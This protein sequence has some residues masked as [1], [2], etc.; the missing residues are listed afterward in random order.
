MSLRVPA[1]L[2]RVLLRVAL[3][4]FI[5]PPFGFGFQRF[6]VR[7]AALVNAVDR[8]AST[9]RME[10]AGMSA[11]R[12]APSATDPERVILYLHGGGYCW[13][14]W[15]THMSLITHLAVAGD[16][17]VYAPNYRLAP[18]HSHPAALEDAL[19]A[20]QWL[21]AQGATPRKL[22][23][24]GDSAG[25]G[26]ALALAVAIK[27][28]GLPLPSSIVLLSPWVDL[29]GDSRSMR[30]K[31]SVEPMLSPSGIRA[32]SAAYLAGRDPQDPAC[33]PLYAE[34]GGLPPVLIQVGTDE[35]LHDDSTR[36]AERCHGAGVE[37]RLKVFDGLWHDFQIHAGV[38]KESDEAVAEIG[39]FLK[40]RFAGPRADG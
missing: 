22:A 4:P 7:L 1:G 34:L 38:M 12:A 18:E 28:C 35:I 20:Y 11:V 14:G 29:R 39:E 24:A 31:A 9:R 32:C 13:G 15:G 26:L 36:L 40:S 5:R 23:I 33:S 8:R 10:I 30:E 2:I 17:A 6:W 16:A 19:A 3:K 21:L 25:G 37:V 27:E